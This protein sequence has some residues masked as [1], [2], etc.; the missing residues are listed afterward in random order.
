MLRKTTRRSGRGA[1]SQPEVIVADEPTATLDA[2]VR[3]KL[4]RLM[5]NLRGHGT[6]FLHI[7]HD[8]ALADGFCDRLV[9]A[10]DGRVVEEGPTD[11]VVS[12]ARHLY[13]AALVAAARGR[14]PAEWGAAALP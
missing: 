7:T 13:T 14:P 5:S 3:A 8:L 10:R 9:V 12:R 6:A 2:P 1:G 4:V 11:Q